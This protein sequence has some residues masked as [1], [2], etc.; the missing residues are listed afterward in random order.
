MHLTSLY[1]YSIQDY[2]PEYNDTT[3][4]HT[5][6][7]MLLLLLLIFCCL[8]CSAQYAVHT[9]NT[10]SR[11]FRMVSSAMLAKCRL[12]LLPKYGVNHVCAR[13]W[14]YPTS[15]KCSTYWCTELGTGKTVPRML[16]TADLS[17]LEESESE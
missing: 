15:G 8:R 5:R 12:L 14:Y 6:S 16:V 10:R 4:R 3:S 7:F 1:I 9:V 17:P 13:C 11:E 2:L